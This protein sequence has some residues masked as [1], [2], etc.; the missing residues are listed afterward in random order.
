MSIIIEKTQI[1]KALENENFEELKRLLSLLSKEIALQLLSVKIN[2]ESL[3]QKGNLLFISK[4]IDY[5]THLP[6]QIKENYLNITNEHYVISHKN[7]YINYENIQEKISS[8]TYKVC[9]SCFKKNKKYENN[10]I[11]EIQKISHKFNL[12]DLQLIKLIAKVVSCGYNNELLEKNHNFS[13]LQNKKLK[14]I[15]VRY[16]IEKNENIQFLETVFKLYEKII[17]DIFFELKDNNQI[18]SFLQNEITMNYRRI[19]DPKVKWLD[20]K[21]IGFKNHPIPY[22]LDNIYIL[23]NHSPDEIINNDYYLKV[24]SDSVS[25]FTKNIEPKYNSV[26]NEQ[27]KNMTFQLALTK[28]KVNSTYKS[29]L[30]IKFLNFC[31]K[32]HLEQNLELN[33]AHN[34]TKTLKKSKI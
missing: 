10:D 1:K 20:N 29:L 32:I 22:Q 16:L 26:I 19:D 18:W 2:F 7:Y 33:L 6:N 23:F 4:I 34:P 31:K 27:S 13:L 3:T 24:I 5:I 30:N 11:K 9:H 17:Y 25:Y 21:K 28:D 15:Y 14:K 12:T 8:F